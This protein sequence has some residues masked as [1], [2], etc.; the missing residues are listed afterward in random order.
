[1][2]IYINEADELSKYDWNDVPVCAQAC[3][4]DRKKGY[5]HK[6]CNREKGK[7]CPDAMPDRV[8]HLQVWDCVWQSCEMEPGQAQTTADIFMRGCASKGYPLPVN[9]TLSVPSSVE[10]DRFPVHYGYKDYCT[11]PLG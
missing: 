10:G 9:M 1:M 5:W 2:D 6:R 8:W 3:R 7:C 4:L 11:S